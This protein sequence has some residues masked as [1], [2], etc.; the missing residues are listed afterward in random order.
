M[1]S[2][3]LKDLFINAIKYKWKSEKNV[4]PA[5]NPVAVVPAPPWWTCIY[6]GKIVSTLM[7]FY[8]HNY[9]KF[10]QECSKKKLN[11]SGR[12]RE[13]K[14]GCSSA[15]TFL[16]L[17]LMPSEIKKKNSEQVNLATR[18][19]QVDKFICSFLFFSS[20]LNFFQYLH[21]ERT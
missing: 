21:Q 12:N 19:Q 7:G 13:E 10:M 2:N 8:E 9:R 3:S 1:Q 5:L 18:F 20:M 11:I 4:T 17:I 6:W 14:G 16:T 15:F